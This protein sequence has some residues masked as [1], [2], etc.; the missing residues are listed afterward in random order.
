MA[1]HDTPTTTG[2]NRFVEHLRNL[3]PGLLVAAAFLG[4]GTITTAS[5][6]GAGNG[7]E[8][9]WALVFGVAAAMVLQE[10]NARLGVVTREG[11]GEALRTTFDSTAMKVV[12]AVLVVSAIGIGGAAFESGNI[13]GAAIGVESIIPLSQAVWSVVIAAVAG[14]LLWS[15][16]YKAIERVLIALVVVMSVVFLLTAIIV[17]PDLSGLLGGFVPSLPSGTLLT[18]VALVGTT[19]VP[20]NFFLHASS[21][22]EKW[23]ESVP[24]DR[25]LSGA[26]FDTV[27][28]IGLGGLVTLA[29]L[30]TAAAAFFQA[31][32]SIE[33]AGDMATQLEP[34][35]GPAAKWFFAIG[36]VAAGVTSAITAPLA[37][38][39][40]ICGVL[41]WGRDLRSTRFRAVW[42][43]T[44]LIGLF[45][46]VIGGSPVQAIVFAQAT[47]GILLPIVAVFLLIVMN[48]SDLLGRHANTTL[49]NV[50]GG[51]VVLVATGL[52]FA[53]LL[54]VIKTISGG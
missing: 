41:G 27:A 4:P 52:G 13:I 28:S 43:A 10:M 50:L 3:G 7:F 53:S 11:L 37:S 39:Y 31:G 44:L 25:A 26:R 21:V 29:V 15:G 6:A 35:L 9:L 40:A 19:V 2:R 8:L 30:T 18:V 47:N 17:R 14:A 32:A 36:L 42:I 24:T 22:Q 51:I 16:V 33:S 20:Y 12:A 46:A 38:S 5:T 23:D 54:D 49:A 1:A 48:R 34:L 45:F